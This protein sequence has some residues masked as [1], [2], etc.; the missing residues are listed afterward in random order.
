MENR[1]FRRVFIKRKW[2]AEGINKFLDG[3]KTEL[4]ESDDVSVY[5]PE[6]ETQE[7]KETWQFDVHQSNNEGKSI[8]NQKLQLASI[9]T[10]AA[11]LNTNGGN[12]FIGVSDNSIEGLDR[13]LQF[14]GGSLDR[15]HLSISSIS[16][17]IGVDKEPYYTIKITEIDGKHICH[18]KAIACQSSKHGLILAD[19]ILFH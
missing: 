12:L 19:P 13:D 5:L 9:K 14:F 15:L 10:V 6:S 4:S 3:Y 8:K 2:I 1:A 16:N 7:Y 17:S 18:I 11:F